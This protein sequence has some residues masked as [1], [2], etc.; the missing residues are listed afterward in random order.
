MSAMFTSTQMHEHTGLVPTSSPSLCQWAESKVWPQTQ[1]MRLIS[2]AWRSSKLK[3]CHSCLLC[4]NMVRCRLHHSMQQMALPVEP[5]PN[6]LLCCSLSWCRP[7]DKGPWHFSRRSHRAH[8][9]L[10]LTEGAGGGPADSRWLG[11]PADAGR[12]PRV[13]YCWQAQRTAEN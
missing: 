4:H 10:Q 3:R 11:H 13:S 5:T 1:C 9:V 8:R 7:A 12:R 6:S 2:G